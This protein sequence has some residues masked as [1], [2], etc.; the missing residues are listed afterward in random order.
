MRKILSICVVGALLTLNHCATVA[1]IPDQMINPSVGNEGS[2]I[3]AL[4]LILKA[5]V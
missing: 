3:S 1:V 4:L 2:V 5:V